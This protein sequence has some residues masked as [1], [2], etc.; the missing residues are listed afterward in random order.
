MLK[1]V[2]LKVCFS[3]VVFLCRSSRTT[4]P[5]WS[6]DLSVSFLFSLILADAA[7]IILT[8]LKFNSKVIIACR[9]LLL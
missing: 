3:Y 1:T 8:I 7:A 9:I 5:N 6:A 4:S 2:Q